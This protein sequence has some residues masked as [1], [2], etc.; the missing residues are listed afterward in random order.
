MSVRLVADNP[1]KNT[2]TVDVSLT[3]DVEK[4]KRFSLNASDQAYDT[5]AAFSRA[6]KHFSGLTRF[7]VVNKG[8]HARVS[9]VWGTHF[10][11]DEEK[12][13]GL[14]LLSQ[15]RSWIDSNALVSKFPKLSAPD[16]SRVMIELTSLILEKPEIADKFEQD[17]GEF[18]LHN[19]EID[20]ENLMVFGVMFGSCADCAISDIATLSKIG[21]DI[22][23]ELMNRFKETSPFDE[24]PIVQALQK[25]KMQPLKVPNGFYTPK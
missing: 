22:K 4:F 6:A 5:S 15:E 21:K 1:S 2:L 8:T 7:D 24:D 13:R 3:S 17:G 25:V 10:W 18:I 23:Y 20:G 16:K 19:V 12:E 11:T 9:L 14:Q